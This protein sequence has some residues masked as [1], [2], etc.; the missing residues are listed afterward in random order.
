MKED[1]GGIGSGTG[2][3]IGGSLQSA[4]CTRRR[5]RP[6]RQLFLIVCEL[7][8]ICVCYQLERVESRFMPG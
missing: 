7:V 2:H 4:L 6:A 1:L 5:T 8:M 3:G